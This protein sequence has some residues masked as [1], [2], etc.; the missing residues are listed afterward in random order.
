MTAGTPDWL[1]AARG[2]PP[3]QRWSFATDAALTE[4]DL[5][6]EAGDVLA[7]DESGGLY[8]LDRRGRI[9]S[10]TRTSHQIRLLAI[11]DEGASGAAV[12]DDTTL[13]WFDGKLQFRWTRD[14]PDEAV[15]LAVS[16]HGTH[17]VVAL[18]SGMNIVYDA[19]KRKTAQFE[20][21]RPLRFLEFLPSEPAI[22]AA[23]DYGFFA[24]YAL[25][26]EMVWNERLWS[27][28]NDLSVSG[29]DGTIA[30]AGLAHG[31]QIYDDEGGSRGSLVMEGTAHRVS[32]TWQR[33]RLAVATLE[34]HLLCVDTE[35]NL[36]WLAEAPDDIARVRL[37]PLGD[38]MIV[39]FTGGRLIRLDMI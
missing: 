14:L 38:Y 3:T 18:A 39:G 15:G 6:R 34:R 1:R 24:R 27:T 13:V 2:S 36:K 10:L 20:S 35:G 30:L 4:C 32:S 5:A 9:Q 28:V 26:G 37:S 19:E 21:L 17:V 16:P 7:A 23:A 12:L 25:T 22:L 29:D 33:K 8:R 31:I 11:A